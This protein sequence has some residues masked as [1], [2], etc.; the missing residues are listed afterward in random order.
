MESARRVVTSVPSALSP[1]SAIKMAVLPGMDF[2]Q[3]TDSAENASQDAV[4]VPPIFL[5]VTPALQV[6]LTLMHQQEL[7]APFAQ[8]AVPPAHLKLY[9]KP[10]SLPISWLEH[11]ASSH[12][13]YLVQHVT[14]WFPQNAPCALQAISLVE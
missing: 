2:L 12:V 3:L 10:V 7:H 9:A 4:Y 14:L 11:Y 8:L 6:S 13:Q 1:D 5:D